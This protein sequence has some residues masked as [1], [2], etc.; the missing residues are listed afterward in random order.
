MQQ[1]GIELIPIRAQN[2]MTTA[3]LFFPIFLRTDHLD[4][5]PVWGVTDPTWPW[6][7]PRREGSHGSRSGHA[8]KADQSSRALKVSRRTCADWQEVGRLPPRSSTPEQKTDTF[9]PRLSSGVVKEKIITFKKNDKKSVICPCSCTTAIQER[10]SRNFSDSSALQLLCCFTKRSSPLFATFHVILIP[11]LGPA[12]RIYL[13]FYIKMTSSR[14]CT[15]YE[16]TQHT[17]KCI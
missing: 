7:V 8:P 4:S 11:V 15:V 6:R 10:H 14:P 3:C 1:W 5:L 17:H 2:D 9:P 13:L 16:W 12:F